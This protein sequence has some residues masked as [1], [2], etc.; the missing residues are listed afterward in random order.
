MTVAYLMHNTYQSAERLWNEARSRKVH[1]L[2]LNILE[3]VP[4]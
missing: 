2:K 1:P 4:R 3:K